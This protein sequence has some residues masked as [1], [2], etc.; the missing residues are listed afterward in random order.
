MLE[1][2]KLSLKIGTFRRG[3]KK[4]SLL[5][6]FLTSSSCSTHTYSSFSFLQLEKVGLFSGFT[7]KQTLFQSS[8]VRF[9][10]E[11]KYCEIDYRV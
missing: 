9:S 3:V 5:L 8:P 10:R 6:N 1:I 4:P 7:D 11:K 2:V